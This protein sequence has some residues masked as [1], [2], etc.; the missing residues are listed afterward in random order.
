MTTRSRCLLLWGPVKVF[1]RSN[2]YSGAYG[3]YELYSINSLPKFKALRPNRSILPEASKSLSR[4]L[5]GT[6]CLGGTTKIIRL[7]QYLP[8]CWY[9][10][11]RLSLCARMKALI[12]NVSPALCIAT[13]PNGALMCIFSSDVLRG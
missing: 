8:K 3:T 11:A 13:V 4:L 12:Q 6:R 2:S 5:P 9:R 7:G 10:S 1:V